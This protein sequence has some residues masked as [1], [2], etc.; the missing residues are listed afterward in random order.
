V[1]ANKTK[2]Y[3]CD[4][5]AVETPKNIS[6]SNLLIFLKITFIQKAKKPLPRNKSEQ[7]WLSVACV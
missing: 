2:R 4:R 3:S 7:Q 5:T 6:H 1:D